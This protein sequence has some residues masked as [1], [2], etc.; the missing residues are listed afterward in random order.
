MIKSGCR[1]SEGTRRK[2]KS[3]KGCATFI[4]RS[5]LRCTPQ[6]LMRQ[7]VLSFSGLASRTR[8]VN[9]HRAGVTLVDGLPQ[10]GTELSSALP[11]VDL[12]LRCLRGVQISGCH[13]E[14]I[15]LNCE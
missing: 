2:V 3:P 14:S 7:T 13:R 10:A 5:R 8:G 15:P 1:A 11:G 4:G 9:S 12:R 6:E